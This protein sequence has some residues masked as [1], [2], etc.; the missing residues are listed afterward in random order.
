MLSQIV[1]PAMILGG[2]PDCNLLK[3]WMPDR[4]IRA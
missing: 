1:I 4:N 2:N 3:S